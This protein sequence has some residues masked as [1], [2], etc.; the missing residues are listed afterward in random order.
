MIVRLVGIVSLCCAQSICW[1]QTESESPAPATAATPATEGA[2]TPAP[3]GADSGAKADP[4]VP[5]TMQDA[6][7]AAAKQAEKVQ[8]QVDA[9]PRA[10]ETAAG[11][12]KPIYML[13]E[14]LSFPMFH[15]VAFALMIAGVVGFALQLVLG[16][17]IV[18]TRMGFSFTE[19]G[20]DAMGLAISLV[21]LVLTTQAAAE[22]STFTSSPAAVIGATAVGAVAGL[23]H[24]W[25][26]T[27]QE[28]Q[29]VRG[30][31]AAEAKAAKKA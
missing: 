29:A 10:Q 28:L 26:G 25:Y 27:A 9:D 12:L 20:S 23:L 11:I 2:E 7:A 30:R 18:L 5:E 13:A 3:T 1:A 19:I 17:L 24:Y 4:V 21:G 15:G 31:V 8:K 22:N 14:Q 16:K 6:V